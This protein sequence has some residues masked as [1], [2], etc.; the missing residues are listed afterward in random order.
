MFS[1][2]LYTGYYFI[3]VTI[4]VTL[5]SA[6]SSAPA[7]EIPED[8]AQLD[9][10][11]VIPSDAD[12]A[13]AIELN[14]DVVYGDTEEVILGQITS[15]TV[16][17][18]R[19]FIADR[20][21]NIIHVYEPDGS[22]L[23]HLGGEGRGPGEFEGIARLKSDDQY[24]YAYDFNQRR[25]NIFE[26]E[27]LEFSH[28]VSL[29][30][31][32]HDI[33]ELEEH[34]PGNY[35]VMSDGNL[36]MGYG[37]GYSNDDLDEERTILFYLVDE[38]GQPSKKII[39]QRANETFTDRSGD[40]FM[41]MYLPFGRQSMLELA[42]DDKIY[43]AWSEDFLIKVH[44]ADGSY[45]RAIYHPYIKSELDKNEILQ[46]YEGD[47]QRSIIRNAE[48]PDT[49][50]ALNSMKI[51][52]EARLW[53]ST[54][55]DNRDEYDWWVIDESGELLAR[56]TWP[57]NRSLIGVSNNILYAIGEEQETGLQQVVRYNIEFL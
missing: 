11:T 41:V 14:E 13:H 15:T 32:D 36:L 9:K 16:A 50:P 10:L 25:I 31:E 46:D 47:R 34:Y 24:I 37:K 35:H 51:D 23:T 42:E 26:L 48:A 2:R 54:V 12:P 53:I 1:S 52:D 19:V 7:D 33:E 17:E 30:N 21:K 27:S 43:T 45:E 56:F 8:V 18:G 44:S 38:E 22:Y 28:A 40:S 29:L 6:C 39:E 49:W 4:L 20:D 57:E 5:L 55:T 3:V